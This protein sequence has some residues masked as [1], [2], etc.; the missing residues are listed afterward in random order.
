MT[1]F[2]LRLEDFGALRRLTEIRLA[3]RERDMSGFPFFHCTEVG[4]SKV[5]FLG[6]FLATEVLEDERDCAEWKDAED[7]FERDL[8][9]GRGLLVLSFFLRTELW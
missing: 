9:S 4:T 1:V 7:D 5:T 6:R 3:R 2:T 8:F